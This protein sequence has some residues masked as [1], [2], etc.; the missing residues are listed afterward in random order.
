MKHLKNILLIALG[1]LIFVGIVAGVYGIVIFREKSVAIKQKIKENE[2]IDKLY[3]STIS[4]P[5]QSKCDFVNNRGT[6]T[7]S[8]VIRSSNPVGTYQAL[9]DGATELDGLIVS[10]SMRLVMMRN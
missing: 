1:V 10:S 8:A 5:S 4:I 6:A 7:Y 3:G 9:A 2:E